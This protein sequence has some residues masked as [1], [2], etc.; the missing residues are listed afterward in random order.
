M[1]YNHERCA[2]KKRDI[3][4]H[5]SE[6]LEVSRSV[7]QCSG[8]TNIFI[9]TFTFTFTF[10][11]QQQQQQLNHTRLLGSLAVTVVH[12][13]RGRAEKKPGTS[14]HSSAFLARRAPRAP[15]SPSRPHRPLLSILLS[16]PATS[17][18][19]PRH[20]TTSPSSP[21]PSH[22]HATPNAPCHALQSIIILPLGAFW[23]GQPRQRHHV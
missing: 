21:P 5:T 16:C 23:R 18:S 1:S 10:H 12:L 4:F 13:K 8:L 15:H 7:S 2:D 20:D 6:I 11:L 9:F 22:H 19:Q 17:A 14:S 3:P